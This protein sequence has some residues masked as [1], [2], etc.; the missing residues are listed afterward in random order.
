MARDADMDIDLEVNLD[1][2]RD[3]VVEYD[4]K[5]G[6]EEMEMNPVFLLIHHIEVISITFVFIII[7][8]ILSSDCTQYGDVGTLRLIMIVVWVVWAAVSYIDNCVSDKEFRLLW[9]KLHLIIKVTKSD[10]CG[11]GMS[12]IF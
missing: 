11:A 10:P 3:D 4:W 1:G 8:N 2:D 6:E 12:E 5:E 9:N 7:F